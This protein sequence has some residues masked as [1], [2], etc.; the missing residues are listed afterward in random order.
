MNLPI[1]FATALLF[2]GGAGVVLADSAFDAA[3]VS[4]QALDDVRGGVGFSIARIATVNGERVADVQV[5]I[6]DVAHMTSGQA[7][8]LARAASLLVVRNGPA[9][10]ARLADLGGGST[11]IQNT[12]NDQRLAVLTTLDVQTNTLGAFRELNFQEGL[13]RA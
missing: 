12:L 6:P 9:N 8:S 1:R 4:E 2:I 7:E 11:L 13:A 5:R 3:P 10:T